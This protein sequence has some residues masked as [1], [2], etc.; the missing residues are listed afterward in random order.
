MPPRPPRSASSTPT[1]TG[2][3]GSGYN[4]SAAAAAADKYYN[5][6]EE[7][8]FTGIAD[9]CQNFVSQSLWAGRLKMVGDWPHTDDLYWWY[10]RYVGNH[11][12]AWT[13]SQNFENYLSLNP[14][15]LYE[16][17]WGPAQARMPYTPD[18][19]TTGD[20][21]FYDWDGDGHIDHTAIQTG[22]GPTRDG[23][24]GN[25][26]DQHTPARLHTFWSGITYNTHFRQTKYT[27]FHINN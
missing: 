3:G 20:V 7:P 11:N 12:N 6:R 26:I 2:P 24:N 14:N 19:V 9:D 21:I 4:G 25:Y 13:A 17:T 22:Y 15:D 8:G 27:F 16:G 5:G 23:L 18:T 10:E 1:S